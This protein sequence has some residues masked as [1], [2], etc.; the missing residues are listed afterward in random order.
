MK[1][2]EAFAPNAPPLDPALMCVSMYACMCVYVS[3]HACVMC[4]CMHACVCVCI[5][6][7]AKQW[8]KFT[9]TSRSKNVPFLD[10]FMLSIVSPSKSS[11]PLRTNLS[12]TERL[13]ALT[14]TPTGSVHFSTWKVKDPGICSS[15]GRL[16]VRLVQLLK[17]HDAFWS[18][19]T[20]SN[21]GHSE[22]AIRCDEAAVQYMYNTQ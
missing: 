13:L 14:I 16:Q 5:C 8:K 20:W 19:D 17:V 12:R 3:V 18:A 11:D 21:V 6:M 15:S 2:G 22:P 7:H 1:R 10:I 9:H 4:V